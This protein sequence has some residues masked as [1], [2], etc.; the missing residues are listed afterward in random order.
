[1]DPKLGRSLKYLP[2]SLFSMFV[3]VFLLDRDNSELVILTVG[4]QLHPS[5]WCHVFLLEVDSTSCLSLILGISSKVPPF[6]SWESLTSQ[7]SRGFSYLLPPEVEFLSVDPHSS[8]L[9]LSIPDHVSLFPFPSP[10]PPSSL[11]PPLCLPWFLSSLSQ[12][13]LNYPH[14]GPSAC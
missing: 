6:E 4:W 1:M 11:P 14:L 9:V 10:L 13:G 2:L 8:T 5:T 3:S 12:V 7:V